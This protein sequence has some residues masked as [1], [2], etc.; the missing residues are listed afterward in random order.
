MLIHWELLKEAGVCCGYTSYFSASMEFLLSMIFKKSYVC[1]YRHPPTCPAMCPHHFWN[2]H[3]KNIY[4]NISV[5]SKPAKLQD[6]YD[7][8]AI[9]AYINI[10]LS[11]ACLIRGIFDQCLALL[12]L[13]FIDSNNYY[14]IS[15]IIHALASKQE[16]DISRRSVYPKDAVRHLFPLFLAC[17]GTWLSEMSLYDLF[18][19]YIIFIFK[20]LGQWK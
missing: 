4:G 18:L 3:W 7:A 6:K 1:K 17:V 12:I 15:M 10:N 19:N 9:R 11:F 8:S 13:E 20:S 5:G 16:P 2:T 14:C